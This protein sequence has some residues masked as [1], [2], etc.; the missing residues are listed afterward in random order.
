M[1][2]HQKPSFSRCVADAASIRTDAGSV[3]HGRMIVARRRE[4]RA[5]SFNLDFG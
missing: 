1:C 2:G 3:G 5:L 4:T